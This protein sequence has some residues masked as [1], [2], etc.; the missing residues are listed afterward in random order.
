MVTDPIA[1]TVVLVGIAAGVFAVSAIPVAEPLFRYFPPV[2]WLYFV[3]MLLSTAGLLPAEHPLYGALAKYALPMALILLTISTDLRAIAAVGVPALVAL[4]V[5]AL[6][7]C[8]GC[9]VALP[10][11]SS[12]LPEDSWRSLAMLAATWIGGSANMVAMQQSLSVPADYVGPVV[13]VDTVVAY[14]WLGLL[15][16][17]SAQQAILNRFLHADLN[18]LDTV[19]T[20]LE[21]DSADF[22]LVSVRSLCI[23][24]GAGF[25]A[26]F[27]ARLLGE[28]LP[29]LGDPTIV[30]ATTWAILASVTAG[31]LLSGSSLGSL[32]R[33]HRAS[34][35]AY[36]ALF[37]LLVSVGAQ[38][39]LRAITE[40]PV[41]LVVGVFVLIVHLFLLTL[42][43]RLL[44]L[45]AFFVAVGS[46]ANIG[47]AVSGPIAAAAYRPALA[48]VGA[49]LGVAGYIL[50]I[51]LPLAVAFVLSAIA[52]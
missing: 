48:P 32:A 24:V 21:H 11:F 12:W 49:L 31:L 13:V 27:L 51:Y 42:A 17:L 14:S 1:L 30:T 3:P 45:P 47:G 52:A 25:V 4:M 35:Y 46:M 36:A 39:D 44:R 50:G 15:I 37:L 20:K 10:L 34:E 41:F 8:V 38:A 22:E 16:A 6:G 26:A 40:A 33:R 19:A 9:I 2:V 28:A 23:V 18:A 43:C 29:E 7:V 5:G